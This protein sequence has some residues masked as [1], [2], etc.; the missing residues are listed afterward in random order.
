MY[1]VYLRSF[2]DTTGDGVGD[3]PGVQ[4]RLEYIRGLG[5]DGIWINPFYRSP[6]EDGGYDVADYF[7]VDPIFGDIEDF[8]GLLS[9]AHAMGM[10]VLI[11]LV[12]NHTSS[13]HE[14]FQA[15]L[16]GRP[17]SRERD[18]YIF[19]RGSG[20]AGVDPPNNWRSVFGGPAWSR[21]SDVLQTTGGARGEAGEPVAD[22]AV[23]VTTG[24]DSDWYLH[25]F[26]PGQPDLNWQSEEVREYFDE[27]LRFWLERGVDGFRIDVAHGM[28]KHPDLPDLDE[29]PA[30]PNDAQLPESDS[31]TGDDP[32]GASPG[33]DSPGGDSPG[34]A[35]PGGASPGGDS[36]G[37]AIA[38]GDH[39]YWD[40]DAVHDIYRRWRKVLD[41][42]PGER[43]FLAEAWV[44][45]PARLARYLRPDELHMAF[46]FDFL[47][48]DW[49]A[50][51]FRET[52][53]STLANLAEVTAIP[54]WVLSNHDVVRHPTRYGGGEVGVERARAALLLM[55]AL[56]GAA[57]LYQGEELGLPEV[58]DLP[59]EVLQDPTFVR[60]G[61]KVRGRDGCRVPL[62]WNE[63]GPS[64]GFSTVE[65]WLP[66]PY[67]WAE[68]SV[69]AEGSD[70]E[71]T[72]N[73]YR[74][75]IGE[76]AKLDAL[77]SD[78]GLEWLDGP[79]CVVAF[80]R[81][82]RFCCVVNCSDD[83]QEIPSAAL[84]VGPVV[85]TSFEVGSASAPGACAGDEDAGTLIPG[86][87]ALWFA[88]PAGSAP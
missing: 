7:D 27:V 49:D 9:E 78:T 22:L 86:N 64:F 67:S 12:P 75:A 87:A 43:V 50:D 2:V 21:V 3:L 30:P 35:S 6:Q 62:P 46:N 1:Q 51:S 15:A 40:R 39:P 69:D 84:A 53:S 16:Y 61:G 32:G 25:L 56:P 28:V 37:S 55:L 18:R 63:R 11:D 73:L 80:T 29:T 83:P 14:W 23:T 57:F 5:V 20:P 54:T 26:A 8:D 77:R 70:E 60:T 88:A 45:S 66:Q 31:P 82:G 59:D 65:A 19:R 41:G 34:G 85:V 10:R 48:C 76:R 44:K 42:Y 68:L 17:G 24:S 72:L 4:S 74:R 47:K 79:P 38:D 71:S 52:I 13:A 81:G 58:L 33:G 36:P